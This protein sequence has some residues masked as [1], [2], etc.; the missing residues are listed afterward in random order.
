[1]KEPS[2]PDPLPAG[3]QLGPYLVEAELPAMRMGRVYRARDSRLKAVV[4]IN[5][6]GV[7]LRGDEGRFRFMRGAHKASAGGQQVHDFGEWLGVPY[8]VV[9]Y[10]EDVGALVD[11]SSL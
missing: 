2:F 4:A 11:V 10:R 3:Y 1:M 6:L 5:V 8:V 9:G 7:D